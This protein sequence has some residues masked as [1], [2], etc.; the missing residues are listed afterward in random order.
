MKHTDSPAVAAV[1]LAAGL[2]TRMKSDMA[3]VLHEV[4]GRPMIQY[5]VETAKTVAG[6]HVVVVVGHQAERVRDVLSGHG[7]LDFALQ[8]RQL[9]TGHAVACAMPR[10]PA[11]C[12]HVLIL[13][14]DVPLIRPQT[15]QGL[16][17]IHFKQKRT[18]TVLAVNAADPTGYGRILTAADGTVVGIVE[19]ADADA[20]Q[21]KI[22]TVNTGI[23][24]VEK[25]FLLSALSQLTTDNA[26]GEFYL[27]DILA[28]GHARKVA[29]G[30]LVA[31]EEA[32]FCG[33]NR[34]EDLAAAEGHMKARLGIIP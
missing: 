12:R 23:Y 28:L 4:L 27:T 32:E 18:V 25:G 13:C 16:L 26:Q 21:K 34:R 8:E 15:L 3:K 20:E 29:V 31:D 9:G 22:R 2:G 24:C 19:E 10:V 5:V 14:G 30:V 17:R 7:P 1:I 33:I 11:A 6:D